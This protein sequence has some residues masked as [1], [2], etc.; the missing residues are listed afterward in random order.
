MESYTRDHEAK[1][2]AR[3]GSVA[4]TL[5]GGIPLIAAQP[6]YTN[7]PA[8]PEDDDVIDPYRRP[9][10]VYDRAGAEISDAIDR[11]AFEIEILRTRV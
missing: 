9:Q 6:G 5:R 2:L 11:I 4:E 8:T 7:A 10:D 1:P 3:A